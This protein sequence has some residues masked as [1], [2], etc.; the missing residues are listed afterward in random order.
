MNYIKRTMTAAAIVAA[1]PM[2]AQATC[3][4][5]GFITRVNAYDDGSGIPT[6]TIYMK[7][8]SFGALYRVRTRDDNVASIATSALTSTVRVALQ[9]DVASC[10]STTGNDQKD[11]GNLRLIIVNP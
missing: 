3:T 2:T 8:G 4:E 7:R 10:P 6:H 9:G 5:Y 11:L 1:L